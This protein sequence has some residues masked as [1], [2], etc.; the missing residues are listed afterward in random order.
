MKRILA[1]DGGGAR[2][3]LPATV[4]MHLEKLAGRLGHR[5]FDLVCGTSTGG[6]IA[7]GIGKAVSAAEIRA[8]YT[9]HGGEI[10]R[11]RWPVYSRWLG[12]PKY[13]CR[14][15]EAILEARLG[16]QPFSAAVTRAMVVA[17]DIE[18]RRT[19]FF[20]SW[21]DSQPMWEVARATSAAPTYFRPH[22]SLIDGGLS[23]NNPAMCAF[24]EARRLWPGHEL[25]IVSLGCG[26]L[27]RPL[28]ARKMKGLL[29]WAPHLVSGFMDGQSDVVDY[30]LRT[31][32]VDYH[33]F[34]CR[35][36]RASDDLDDVR[37][38]QIAALIAEAEA[39]IAARGPELEE[40]VAKLVAGE[41]AT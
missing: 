29:A 39:L 27:T 35:L 28:E 30:Q 13:D 9:D 1:V 36:E 7:C 24:A 21:R 14:P 41:T 18:A 3:I 32:P 15:L 38:E 11:R 10:F 8:L 37:P 16:S 23:A 5:L 4:L 33:R 19:Y 17:Y 6:I 26:E 40:V 20:K 31:L 34:Q 22:G 12:A 2:G 25:L